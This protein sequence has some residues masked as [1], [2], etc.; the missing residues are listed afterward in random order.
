MD[1]PNIQDKSPN[2]QVI[3]QS[4]SLPVQSTTVADQKVTPKLNLSASEAQ[5]LL[6]LNGLQAPKVNK[7]QLPT[8]LIILIA[9][10]I[11]FA[12]VTS[13][14]VAAVKPGSNTSSSGAGSSL[15]GL[16]KQSNT[17]SANGTSN[18]INQD[19]KTCSDPVNAATVC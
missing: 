6:A 2:Q 14:L 5:S 16:P 13:Y 4:T 18:Q 17:N 8:K 11:V 19:V 15:L 7:T 1:D 9:G 3:T 10:L 12:I